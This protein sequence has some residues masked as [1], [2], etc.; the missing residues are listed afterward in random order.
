MAFF[1]KTVARNKT[2]QN[3]ISNEKAETE[4]TYQAEIVC[5]IVC[6]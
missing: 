4:E 6:H 2:K 3:Y 5:T 1:R